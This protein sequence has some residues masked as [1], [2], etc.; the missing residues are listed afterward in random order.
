VGPWGERPTTR[1]PP[2]VWVVEVDSLRVSSGSEDS[3][4][5]IGLNPIILGTSEES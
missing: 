1:S 2:A 4:W 5:G 3:C